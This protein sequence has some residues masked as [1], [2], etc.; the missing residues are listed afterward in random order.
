MTKTTTEHTIPAAEIDQ[1][2]PLDTRVPPHIRIFAATM[3]ED[4]NS[5]SSI[6]VQGRIDPSTLRFLKVDQSYQ[7]PL[8]DRQDIF[9]A[10]GRGIVVPPIEIGVRG[11][12]VSWDGD[13]CIIT[14]PVYIIDGWQRVGTALKI[15]D[16]VPDT[17]LRLFATVHFGTNDVWERHR[18]TALNKNIRKVSPNLHLRNMR[19]TN[20]AVATLY[21]LSNNTREFALY[22]KICWSQNMR[23]DEFIN[24]RTLINTALY[25]HSHHTSIYTGVEKMAESAAL[26]AHRVGLNK[27]RQNVFTFFE[28]VDECFG[29]QDVQYRGQNT[30]LKSTFLSELARMFSRHVDFWRDDDT[31]LFI[32]ADQ[33]RKVAKLPIHDPHVRFLAGGASNAAILYDLLVRHM[34][35]GRNTGRLVMRYT[36]RSEK[37]R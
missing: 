18:F 28:V 10:L 24:A 3:D 25:L 29:L 14:H 32:S 6:V 34:N 33:R 1:A 27:F 31:K 4:L 8:S 12:D 35:S 17:P 5:P 26:A 13:D 16:A 20:D 21:G 15:L 36:Q 22:R 9:E 30:H 23:R 37:D 19:D 11:N 2:P 7:R